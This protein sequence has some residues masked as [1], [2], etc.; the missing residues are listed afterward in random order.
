MNWLEDVPE[1]DEEHFTAHAFLTYTLGARGLTVA[2]LKVSPAV[3]ATFQPY[4]Y[5]ALCRMTDAEESE[6]W[7]KVHA[8]PI[9]HGTFDGVPVSIVHFPVGAPA[10]VTYLEEI[11]VGGAR[12]VL[13]VGAAGSLQEYAPI[14]AAVIPTSALRE[15]GTSYHYQ[16]PGIAAVPDAACVAALRDACHEAGILAHEGPVWT[17]DAPFREL[18]SKV[19]RLARSGVVAVDMEASA[20]YIVGA[21]RG[22]RVAS[23]FIV[24][25]ELFHPW[26]PAFFDRGYRDATRALA[27]CTLAAAVRLARTARDGT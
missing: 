22:L 25:D 17:T 27:R 20:L 13:A 5:G 19:R 11:A 3:V 21:M 7:R 10:A 9:A 14:G 12:T 1:S 18:T 6:P 8:F 16:P 24:S 23:L 26:T 2:D 4:I 15:E